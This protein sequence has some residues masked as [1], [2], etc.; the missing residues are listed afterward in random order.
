VFFGQRP[1]C[2]T[3][4]RPWCIAGPDES[5]VR[6]YA[7]TPAGAAALRAAGSVDVA[8]LA[9]AAKP[10]QGGQLSGTHLSFAVSGL[11]L[12]PEAVADAVQVRLLVSTA[13]EISACQ[14][15]HPRVVL[16]GGTGNGIHACPASQA[17]AVPARPGRRPTERLGS[18][19]MLAR[20][21]SVERHGLHV[22]LYS[23]AL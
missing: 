11:V 2:R 22:M 4:N 15:A 20:T 16:T 9:P 6:A 1:V 10:A 18:Q 19:G 17:D 3:A 14:G 7:V 5:V 23:S 13:T 12:A 21:E 8:Q